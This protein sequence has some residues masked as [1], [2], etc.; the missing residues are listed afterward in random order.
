M[1]DGI[2]DLVIMILILAIVLSV[3]IAL[4]MPLVRD[5][6][7]PDNRPIGDT[8]ISKTVGD[9]I[10]YYGDYD[11]T[12]DALEVVLATQ[13]A[14]WRSMNPKQIKIDAAKLPINDTYED[15][16]FT[17]AENNLLLRQY[18]LVVWGKIGTNPSTARY[19]YEYDFGDPAAADDDCYKL[20]RVQ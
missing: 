14:D 9:T 15:D 18:A 20:I 5:D 11:A 16:L 2:L 6:I 4:V 8:T 13:I 17:I 19:R 7:T 3:S 1:V 10:A 12:M